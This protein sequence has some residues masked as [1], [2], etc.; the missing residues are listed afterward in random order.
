MKIRNGF[1]SN[2]S[3][4]SFC[5][6]GMELED[7]HIEAIEKKYAGHERAKEFYADEDSFDFDEFL[8][9]MRNEDSLKGLD[10]HT[11]YEAGMTWVGCSLT[12]IKDDQTMGEFKEKVRSLISAL[13][14][15]EVDSKECA[16][17]E[18]AWMG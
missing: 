7:S 13:F 8:W 9:C 5:I 12:T 2:S 16:I 1:V 14:G 3:T 15:R 4:T 10:S 11:H 18:H 17:H 6:Y